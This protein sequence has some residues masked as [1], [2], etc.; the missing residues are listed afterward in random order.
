[1]RHRGRWLAID[2]ADE[3]REYI[4]PSECKL[5]KRRDQFTGIAPTVATAMGAREMGIFKG[6]WSAEGWEFLWYE[7]DPDGRLR[8]GFNLELLD[9]NI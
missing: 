4:E 9:V 1:M 7:P 6:I 3:H 2:M 8:G 5:T